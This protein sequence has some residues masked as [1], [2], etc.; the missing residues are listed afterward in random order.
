MADIHFGDIGT[1]F[2]ATLTDSSTGSAIDVSSASTKSIIFRKPNDTVETK[3]ASFTTDG[4]D[5]KIEYATVS[6]DLDAIGTWSV[7]GLVSGAT[8][9]NYTAVTTFEVVKNL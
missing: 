9:T 6:G 1:I 4:T 2:R 7:Q 5:G 3:T 8:F